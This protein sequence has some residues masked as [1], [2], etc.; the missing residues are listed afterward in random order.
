M[1]PFSSIAIIHKDILEGRLTEDVFAADLWEVFMGRGPEEYRNPDLFFRRTYLT[2]GL[3]NLLEVARKRLNGLGGDPIIQLQT[4]FGGGKT[5]ALIALFHRAKAWGV[6][7]VVID[8][9][10][11]D[12]REQTLWGEIERQLTGRVEMFSGLTPP[13]KEKLRSLLRDSQPLLILMDE[14]LQ[15]TT[16]AAS[17][18]VGG[19]N[20][21]AQV[22]AFMHE[23]TGAVKSLDKCLLVLTLPTSLLEHYDESAEKLFHQLQKITGRMEKVYT[24]VRDEEIAP[25]IRRRL[26]KSVDEKEAEK[27][28]DEFLDYAEREDLLPKGIERSEYKR[29]FLESYPFQPEVINILYTRWGSF[30]TFQRTRGVLRLLSLVIYSLK[31]SNIP[32]IRLG[33]FD[34]SNDEIRREL[35]K[36]IGPQYDSVIASDITG[37]NAGAKKVDKALGKSY[38]AYNFGTRVATTIFLYSF[39][40]GVEK[41]ATL[42]DLKLTCAE[43]GTP[44]SIII[45]AVSKLKENLF[46]LQSDAK[47]YFSDQPNLNKILLTKM[48]NITDTALREEEEKLLH[49]YLSK[50]PFE[51][52]LWP[53]KTKDVP[54]TKSLKLVILDNGDI[55]RIKEFIDSCGEKPRVNRNVLLFLCPDESERLNF[56]EFL[57]RKIAWEDIK[58]DETL[59]LTDPQRKEVDEKVRDNR[60]LAK[61]KLRNF[62]RIIYLPSKDQPEKVDMGIATFGIMKGLNEEI[63][64]KLVEDGKIAVKLDPRFIRDKYMKDDYVE[65]NKVLETFYRT[66][67]EIRLLSDRVLLDSIKRGVRD[68]LFGYGTLE[69]DK[70]VCRYFREEFALEV[71]EG[72]ILIKPELCFAE[73]AI[74]EEEL[75][76]LIEEIKGAYTTEELKN[77]EAKIPWDKLSEDQ[78]SLLE[79]ELK[80]RRPELE[81]VEEGYR[82]INLELSVPLGRL[83][84]VVRM[85]NYLRTKFEGVDVKVSI[86]AKQ[87]KM[88]PEEYKEKVKEAIAQSQIKVDKED[89]R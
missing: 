4:P 25:I 39:S 81:E 26:F 28:I 46:F 22:L 83:S 19:S 27:I 33:D 88:T 17:V 51:V 13:G 34:L 42:A 84:D 30:A 6:N 86:T 35:V 70:P 18:R 12:P 66:P 71:R 32:F 7:V 24:P 40:G 75:Q 11:L 76:S 85:I 64:D 5:H 82:F 62:Y 65:V 16:K 10:A 14:I 60:D 41:G 9:T 68:G 50:E 23:F 80:A 38:I 45:E 57:R 31:E 52:Y 44:S 73:R 3:R 15:Y 47:L 61:R 29:M 48:E 55:K 43:I 87:G 37:S 49:Q 89:L 2:N 21:A 63:Y 36:H 77:V 67:G 79:R 53:E 54:D 59:A 78:R 20:L 1:K 56:Y 8:G 58:H 69:G 72:D 74:P